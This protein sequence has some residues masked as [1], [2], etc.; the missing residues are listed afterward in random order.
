[1]C[2]VGVCV[3]SHTQRHDGARVCGTDIHDT[4]HREQWARW[5]L[6][7]WRWQRWH[8]WP[9][10]WWLAQWRR[11]H[12]PVGGKK[13]G[14]TGPQCAVAAG[15]TWQSRLCVCVCVCVCA[16]ALCQ[17]HAHESIQYTNTKLATWS[18]LGVSTHHALP[19]T[20]VGAVAVRVAPHTQ[21]ANGECL[22][23]LHSGS[24][25]GPIQ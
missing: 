19:C 11:R 3:V 24:G 23:C 12:G 1:M 14:E 17:Q 8:G 13:R 20:R 9:R 21:T 4:R 6:H 16:G 18:G 2:G 22:A 10:A 5:R 15:S 25:S 7:C